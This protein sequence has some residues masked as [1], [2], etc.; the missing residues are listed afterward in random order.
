MTDLE[1]G[2]E[3]VVDEDDPQEGLEEN[4]DEEQ[5]NGDDSP[6][7]ELA[8]EMG[9]VPRDK[10]QGPSEDWKPADEFIRAGR[11]IQR[12]TSRE[13]KTVRT[14]LD[15]IA[16]TNAS[17]VKQQV[18]ER[19][20]EVVSRYKKAV[21]DGDEM[22]ALRLAGELHS[23]ATPQTQGPPQ[24]SP[25]TQSWVERNSGW[26]KQ[27]GFEY[28]TARAIEIC[29]TLAGQGYTDHATQLRI[30]EQRLRQEMP[31]VFQGMKNG[32]PPAGV[33]APGSRGAGPSSRQKGF[34]DLPQKSQEIARDMEERGVIKS[35][36]DFAKNYFANL[37]GKA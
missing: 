28:A 2:A 22:T 34:A 24:P 7:A 32:K 19:F 33:H 35:R 29:N 37:E 8:G 10:F 13:L 26:F 4:Q 5:S 25:E 6:Y 23:L 15:N 17:I 36:D 12:D 20:G 21:D 31:Q 14:Q 30:A 1:K 3:G 9:W 11:D 16:K 27:P 18:Q